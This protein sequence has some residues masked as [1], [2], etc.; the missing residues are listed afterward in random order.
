MVSG[1]FDCLLDFGSQ[2]F[3]L[4]QINTYIICP[5]YIYV[6]MY[7]YVYFLFGFYSGVRMYKFSSLVKFMEFWAIAFSIFLFLVPLSPLSEVW[8]FELCYT[9]A[10]LAQ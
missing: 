1:I 5:E 3:I 8:V 10:S 6:Y 4:S 2:G 7:L 9:P